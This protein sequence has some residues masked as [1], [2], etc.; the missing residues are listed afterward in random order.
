[1]DL[2]PGEQELA[3]HGA[4]YVVLHRV[5]VS[6]RPDRPLFFWRVGHDQAGVFY[7][8]HALSADDAAGQALARFR[9]HT[10]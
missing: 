7:T 6:I 3:R 9:R 5:D 2:Q 4:W 8:G 10:S 1:M